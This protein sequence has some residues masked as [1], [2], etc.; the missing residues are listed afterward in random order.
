[1][2]DKIREVL[3]PFADEAAKY[4]P[5]ENDGDDKLWAYNASGLRL[6]HLREARRLLQELSD[7]VLTL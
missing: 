1:M 2:I 6:K 7:E 3:R 5:D 4:D